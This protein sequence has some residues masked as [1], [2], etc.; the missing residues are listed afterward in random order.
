M[1]SV[2][3]CPAG[4]L[5]RSR[6]PRFQAQFGNSVDAGLE[7]PAHHRQRVGLQ[8]DLP[9]DIGP[10]SVS[11]VKRA[12]ILDRLAIRDVDTQVD[13]VDPMHFATAEHLARKILQQQKAIKKN[14]KQPDFTG[15]DEY[16]RHAAGAT[17]EM[18]APEWDKHVSELHRN[19]SLIDR[20]RRIAADEKELAAAAAGSSN[21][22]KGTR[23]GKK[24]VRKGAEADEDE[25]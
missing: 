7:Q 14:P 10:I 16:E 8:C 19:Q 6:K 23:G 2:P 11:G 20:N 3:Q 1:M 22:P 12:Q 5:T 25:V 18:Y 13:R 4:A 17:D 21:G 15:L 24:G 9:Q